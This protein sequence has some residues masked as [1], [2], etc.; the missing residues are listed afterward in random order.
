MARGICK[1]QKHSICLISNKSRKH[2]KPSILFNHWIK[3]TEGRTLFKW[4]C[5]KRQQNV[6]WSFV[7]K[8]W[9]FCW[10]VFSRSWEGEF[11]WTSLAF[12]I[13]FEQFSILSAFSKVLKTARQIIFKRYRVWLIMSTILFQSFISIHTLELVY[14]CRGSRRAFEPTKK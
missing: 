12:I 9:N 2:F 8:P 6:S 7:L 1:K 3:W 13:N 4:H 14:I 10:F 11:F 5:S